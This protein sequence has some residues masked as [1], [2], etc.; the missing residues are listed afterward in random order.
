MYNL[1]SIGIGLLS[2]ILA[3]IAI[4]R[5]GSSLLGYLSMSA[6]AI[7]MLFQFVEDKRLVQINDVSAILDTAG[8]RLFGAAVLVGVTLFLN[9][10][11]LWISK[12]K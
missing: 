11:N 12:K 9:G 8:G 6:C 10:L 2:W 4:R 7:A 3:I 5:R 1:L